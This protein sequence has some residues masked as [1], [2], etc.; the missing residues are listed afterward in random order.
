MPFVSVTMMI[1]PRLDV[2]KTITRRESGTPRAAMPRL[3]AG[4]LAA[5]AV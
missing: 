5:P 4:L 3:P 1:H 2:T